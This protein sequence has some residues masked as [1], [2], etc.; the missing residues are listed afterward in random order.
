METR[1]QIKLR[2]NFA[3]QADSIF[4]AEHLENFVKRKEV[5]QS[6]GVQMKMACNRQ[7]PPRVVSLIF[8]V[9]EPQHTVNFTLT[10]KLRQGPFFV[11]ELRD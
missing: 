7:K 8:Q 11:K 2:L 3:W 5:F 4:R 1:L 10:V 9:N 6:L